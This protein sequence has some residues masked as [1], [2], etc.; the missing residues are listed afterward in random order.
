MYDN[1]KALLN[2]LITCWAVFEGLVL[3]GLHGIY[4]AVKASGVEHLLHLG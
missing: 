1:A 4:R 2:M 3:E